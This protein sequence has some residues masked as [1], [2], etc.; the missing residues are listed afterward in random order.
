M[1]DIAEL[2][3]LAQEIRVDV[4][5][6]VYLAKS[7]HIGGSFSSADIIT[8]LYFYKMNVNPELPQW[9]DRDR[10]VLSKGHAAPALYA[11]LAKRGF[12]DPEEC[13][14]LRH[15]D[16]ILQGATS[17]RTPGIDMTSGPLGQGL[18]AAVGM[19]CAAK[20]QNKVYKTYVIIGDGEETLLHGFLLRHRWWTR[21]R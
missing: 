19:A 3:K 12:F 10:F 7:G 21:R 18:S 11:A 5:N 8:A 14:H 6:M 17:F 4:L 13:K 15:I 16:H 1:V 20:I 9:E 2:K